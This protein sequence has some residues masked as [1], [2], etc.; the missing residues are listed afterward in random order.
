[1][2]M[3]LLI[4]IA[5]KRTTRARR[6]V[7]IAV[8]AGDEGSMVVLCSFGAPGEDGERERE[9]ERERDREVDFWDLVMSYQSGEMI[10]ARFS[11]SL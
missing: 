3:E 5:T 6:A 8:A 4:S 1:M 11:I 2:S 10:I 9:R 7:A